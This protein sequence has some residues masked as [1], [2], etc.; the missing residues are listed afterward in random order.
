M[1]CYL[2]LAL[3]SCRLNSKFMRAT[4]V[5]LSIVT[6]RV[7]YSTARLT[8][9]HTHTNP[10]ITRDQGTPELLSYELGDM[11]AAARE[12]EAEAQREEELEREREKEREREL[13]LHME[14][15]WHHINHGL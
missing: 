15:V 10:G 12:K 8:N 7:Y 1:W 14:M 6:H 11:S 5:P 3:V 2:F 13:Q 4:L 9:T